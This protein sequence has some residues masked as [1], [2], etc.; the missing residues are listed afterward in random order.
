[1]EARVRYPTMPALLRNGAGL[2]ALAFASNG[3]LLY[4]KTVNED[5][6]SRTF[7]KVRPVRGV[8]CLPF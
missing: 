6:P 7:W 4:A 8:P 1:M 5:Q 3:S 2:K